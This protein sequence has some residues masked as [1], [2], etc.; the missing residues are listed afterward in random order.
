M[1]SKLIRS[2]L[3]MSSRNYVTLAE[4]LDFVRQYVAIERMLIGE[5]FEFTVNAPEHE[6]LRSII[7][8]SMLI[9]IL[10]ENAIQHGLKNQLGHKVLTITVD[11]ADE[12]TRISVTDNGP[13]FD[14]RQYNSER[15]R[16]GLNIIR[17][18]ISSINQE[19]KKLKMRFDIHNDNGC[20]ATITIP[21][22]ISDVALFS[23]NHDQRVWEVTVAGQAEPVRLKRSINNEQ[24]VM[25]DNRFI[26]VSQRHIININ[27]LKGVSEGICR[28]YPPFD[29]IDNV[30]IGRT[31]R[32]NLTERFSTL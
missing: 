4:E 17:T 14:I 31:F 10:V 24:L 12:E 16:T 3:D 23:Y 2:N 8:P 6:L 1:M 28:L 30:K 29:K 22:N 25:L 13:G 27:Y 19:N 26:Q 21:K 9:Q 32:K 11:A 18:T 5:D 15:S 20:H 7:V